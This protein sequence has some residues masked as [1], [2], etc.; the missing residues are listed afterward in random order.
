[1]RADAFTL[2]RLLPDRTAEIDPRLV[3]QTAMVETFRALG[4]TTPEA[5]LAIPGEIV[6]G[7]PDRHVMRVALAGGRAAYLKREHCIRW[8]DRFRNWRAN[9]GWTSKS[10]REGRILQELEQRG[11]PGPRWLAFG[12]DGRGRAFLLLQEAEQAI[13]LRRAW[14][15]IADLDGLAIQLGRL[16]AELHEAGVDHPDLW[17]KHFLIDPVTQA[18]TLIDWPSATLGKSVSWRRRVRA[19]AALRA[20][21]I[22][23]S[24]RLAA[25]FLWAYLRVVRTSETLGP[26][27]RKSDVPSF[28][29]LAGRIEREAARLLRRR[30]VRQQRQ[31]PLGPNAQRLIWLDGEALCAIPEVAGDLAPSATQKL[32]YYPA[33]HAQVFELN[34]R[35]VRLEVSQRRALLGRL[36]SRLRAAAWRA[37]EVRKARLLFHLERHHVATPK[38]LAYGQR[39]HGLQAG[40]FLLTEAVATTPLRAAL[41]DP[42]EDNRQLL[43]G[44]LA[45]TLNRLHEAGC[46]AG[47]L[48]SFA[49][50]Q[51]LSNLTVV[52]ADPDR[53]T[54]RK[55]LHVC[56]KKADRMRIVRSINDVCGPRFSSEVFAFDTTSQA[57]AVPGEGR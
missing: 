9:F 32:L 2:P 39:C 13:D 8:K 27:C 33:G 51:D 42:D 11:L 56:R 19:L 24:N 12:E 38:L 3:V 57:A 50:R 4:L 5:F 14:S 30:G 37:P 1:M 36:W 6:S 21:L 55:Q 15:D 54:F 26:G 10:V 47:S 52:V 22:Q 44:R 49:V 45:E 25:R 48:D 31:P 16:C 35:T 18:I 29:A 17:S 23:P 41:Q 34:G 7:H 46:E 28:S 40:A 20:T 53:L 43:L